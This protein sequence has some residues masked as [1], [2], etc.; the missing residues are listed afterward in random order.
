MLASRSC[1]VSEEESYPSR[2]LQNNFARQYSLLRVGEQTQRRHL[3]GLANQKSMPKRRNS[4][5]V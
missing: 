2:V 3:L 5:E 1:V 4:E